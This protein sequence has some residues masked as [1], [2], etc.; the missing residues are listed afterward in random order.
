LY[1]NM[2]RYYDPTLG[3]Y[4]HSDPIGL[5]GGLNTY[6][7]AGGNPLNNIDPLGTCGQSFMQGIQSFLQGALN[8]LGFIWALP[9]TIIGLG[10][11]LVGYGISAAAYGLGLQDTMPQIQILH[12]AIE[13]TNN[14]AMFLG[15]AMTLGFTQMFA[16]LESD[17]YGSG[18]I[19]WMHEGAHIPQGEELGPLYIPAAA[20]SLLAGVIFNGNSHGP[21]SFMET[22]PDYPE[23]QPWP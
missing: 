15:G 9:D 10:I 7:Y 1:Y 4:V 19:G 23:P 6:A 20:A 11:G 14:V 22:G 2:N 5:G 3:R 17:L 13:F 12:G 16:G 21:A 8:V 18:Q